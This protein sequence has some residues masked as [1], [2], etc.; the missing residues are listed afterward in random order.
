MTIRNVA[1]VAPILSAGKPGTH[2]QPEPDAFQYLW[3]IPDA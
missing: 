3:Q 2:A 1:I